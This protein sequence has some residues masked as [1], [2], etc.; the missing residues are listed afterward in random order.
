M[1]VLVRKSLIV[2]IVVLSLLLLVCAVLYGISDKYVNNSATSASLLFADSNWIEFPV[3]IN[4]KETFALFD[5]GAQLCVIDKSYIDQFQINVI[6]LNIIQINNRDRYPLAIIEEF[7]I[8]DI[9]LRN[10]LAVV[11]DF[12][13]ENTSLKCSESSLIVGMT[14]IKQF[15]WHFDFQ[16]KK[17]DVSREYQ[18]E[19]TDSTAVSM[20]YRNNSRPTTT[21]FV[22]SLKHDVLID[23]GF[24]TTLMLPIQP[25]HMQSDLVRM[26]QNNA[27]SNI[28][29]NYN[30]VGYSRISDISWENETLRNKLITYEKSNLSLIGLRFFKNY[31]S[32]TLHPF[33][34]KIFFFNKV[35][36]SVRQRFWGHGF[37]VD[38]KKDALVV[39]AVV[40]GSPAF[41]AGISI[42][43]TILGINGSPVASTWLQ[44]DYCTF[45]TEK[46]RLFTSDTITL[47]LQKN[48]SL[49]THIVIRA[50][51]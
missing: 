28:F 6:P 35:Q 32:I 25:G 17:M 29:G 18:Y 38:K 33:Q 37:S 34:K 7:T 44:Y 12:K 49:R 39:S 5:T 48:D 8:G 40:T 20:T 9:K 26:F 21:L 43:D 31:H 42:N 41:K 22:D 24:N 3:A 27:H 51:Y 4:G 36:Q 16:K 46:D 14:V 11:M 19:V 1:L 30:A 10:V 13:S 15:V 50:E 45:L 47:Q 2:A 23:F